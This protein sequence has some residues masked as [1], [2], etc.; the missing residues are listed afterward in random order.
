MTPNNFVYD[1]ISDTPIST[2][3]SW[4]T[5]LAPYDA[6]P[7]GIEGGLLYKFNS[8]PGIYHCPAD[9]S[10]LETKAGVK[11]PQPRLRSY[12]MSQSVNGVPDFN[13]TLSS[14]DP[15]FTRSTQIR[16]PGPANC[17]VFLDVHEDEI[18]DTQFG[19][20]TTAMFPGD[21]VWWDLPANRHNQGANFSFADGHAEHWKWQVPKIFTAG[22][23]AEQSVTP[24]EMGDYRRMQSGFRQIFD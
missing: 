19:M 24:G 1:I 2:G 13:S 8:T 11:L 18:I 21:N 23:G 12:N 15:A 17:F 16:N 14:L 20:P 3:A 4:C 7:A 10:T 6:N 9:K 22:R 5:N